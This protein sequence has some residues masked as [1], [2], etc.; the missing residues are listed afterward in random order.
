MPPDLHF[1]TLKTPHFNIHYHDG[2]E[3]MAQDVANAGEESLAVIEKTLSWHVK[4]VI[5]VA[6]HDETDDA[7]GSAQV[8]PYSLVNL[9]V[10]APDDLNFLSEYSDWAYELIGHELTHI[11]HLNTVEGLP[12]I[13]NKVIGPT[14]FPNQYQARWF[15]EGLAVE[16]ETRISEGGRIRSKMADMVFRTEV[17]EGKQMRLDQAVSGPIR[18][19]QATTWYLHGGRFL[20]WVANKWGHDKLEALS[21]LYGRTLIPYAMNRAFKKIIGVDYDDAWAEFTQE[22]KDHY[23]AQLAPVY[24]AGVREGRRLTEHGQ[25]TYSP[26]RTSDGKILYF[27]ETQ[28]VIPQAR[29]VDPVTGVSQ[30]VAQITSGAQAS[31]VD[32]DGRFF[33]SQFE[34]SGSY[35]TY[36][37]LF[38]GDLRG[39]SRRLSHG[40]RLRDPEVNGSWLYLIRSVGVKTQLV[41]APLEQGEPNLDKLEVLWDPERHVQMYTPRV[42]PDGHYLAVSVHHPPGQRDIALFDLQNHHLTYVTDDDA[43]DGGPVFSPD[44]T[45]LY[46]HSARTGI[47]NI[48]AH[49]MSDGAEFQVTNVRTGALSPE[50][51]PD[52][53]QLTYVGYTTLGYDLF[54]MPIAREAWAVAPG[55]IE[56]RPARPWSKLREVYQTVP[57]APLRTLLPHAWMPFIDA[58]ALGTVIGV[59]AAASD[60]LVRHSWAADIGYGVV[61]K[62]VDYSVGYQNR[63]LYPVISLEHSRQIQS[64]PTAALI[65]GKSTLVIDR[66]H[67]FGIDLSVPFSTYLVRTSLNLGYH[68]Q[69]HE[70][71]THFVFMPDSAPPQLPPLGDFADLS[72]SF[73]L[74]TTRRT[75]GAVS[76]EYGGAMSVGGTLRDHWLGSAFRQWSVG[77]TAQY[78]QL[79]PW[80]KNHV[81]AFRAQM[82]GGYNELTDRPLYAIGGLPL[83]DFVRDFLLQTGSNDIGLRG[84]N[85]GTF[86]GNAEY[87][88]TLEYRAPV[89]RIEHG[90]SVFP[91]YLRTLGAAA[92]SDVG[93]AADLRDL[94][95]RAA[96]GV[97]AELRL[98]FDYGFFFGGTIRMGYARGVTAH[99]ANNFYLF[100][101][102]GF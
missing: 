66:V 29:L 79:M 93:N 57:Y 26:R 83:R 69:H 11:V 85:F 53:T 6:L 3:A 49:R 31:R 86:A 13:V 4:D 51:S 98:D 30:R 44:G 17:V 58:D 92:F 74:D 41:R 43:M 45:Y 97:G 46:F 89:W 94:F 39:R 20:T 63:Q 16:M 14:Y 61:S 81:L 62:D 7:N 48:F 9:Y 100:L 12:A 10:T 42:S 65:D 73:T 23:D 36:L 22:L 37:D 2:Y 80:L 50:L 33:Y 90:Y 60:P 78:F 76:S 5:E 24:Q 35:Y 52:G 75:L 27:T 77:G 102:N 54:T 8:Q 99:G 19:P 68:Y 34:V 91:F 32:A 88:G 47:F 28:S 21:H 55:D 38:E 70:R 84:F 59:A 71:L 87:I 64:A 1:Q 18:F 101:S 56:E 72:A 95:K 67:A 25:Y 40:A 96:V 82:A 15:I